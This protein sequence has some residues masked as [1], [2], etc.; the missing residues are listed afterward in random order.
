MR[1]CT[2]SALVERVLNGFNVT[3]VSY[4]PTGTGKSFSILGEGERVGLV[5][6]VIDDVFR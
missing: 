1:S 6:R 3:I 4:G 2:G 5:P